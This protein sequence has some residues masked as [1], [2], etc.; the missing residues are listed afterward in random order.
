MVDQI[1]TTP[2]D[3]F[4]LWQ[5]AKYASILLH[6]P[7]RR[8]H[9]FYSFICCL[10]TE[11]ERQG[12][13]DRL[14]EKAKKLEGSDKKT[15]PLQK[16][17]FSDLREVLDS[18]VSKPHQLSYS[19]ESIIEKSRKILDIFL[20]E[21]ST[22]LTRKAETLNHLQKTSLLE[23]HLIEIQQFFQLNNVDI[24]ILRFFF[25][26]QTFEPARRYFLTSLDINDGYRNIEHIRKLLLISSNDI[27][28][29]LGEQG[30]LIVSGLISSNRKSLELSA[31][32]LD[33]LSGATEGPLTGHFFRQETS[34]LK[35]SFSDFPFQPKE[36][37][38]LQRILSSPIGSNIIF[39]GPPGAG[40][41]EFAKTLIHHSGKSGFFITDT[42][43]TAVGGDDLRR[44][45]LVAATN[46]LPSSES[47]I[48]VDEAE[49]IL[50]L[51]GRRSLGFGD[52]GLFSKKDESPDKAWINHF[53][54][55]SK[56]QIIWIVNEHHLLSEAVLRRFTFSMLFPRLGI[57]HREKAWSLQI[58]K[59]NANFISEATIKKL[60]RQFEVSPAAIALAIDT[61]MG[62]SRGKNNNLDTS[63]PSEVESTL[64]TLLQRHS[65]LLFGTSRK[66]LLTSANFSLEGLNTNIPLTDIIESSRQFLNYLETTSE[67]SLKI[68]N[69]NVLLFGPPGTGKTE[70]A[71][72]LA[73]SLDKNIQIKRG[74]D[75]LSKWVGDTEKNIHQAFEQAEAK[76]DILFLDESDSLFISREGANQSW[77]VS[78]T[79]E[80]LVQMEQFKGIL[81][82]STNFMD[83][84]DH[85]AIRRFNWKVRFE[86]LT[87][88]GK[89]SFYQAI[90]GSL[91]GQTMTTL[92]QNELA[93]IANLTPGDFKVVHQKNAFRQNVTHTELLASLAM[94]ASLKSKQFGRPI[95]F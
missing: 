20:T 29:A 73:R 16:D 53:L 56:H 40:K 62:M 94:E 67:A 45:A 23:S 5:T 52:L 90:L 27:R 6:N 79:S 33:Y 14:F 89:L 41:T 95:G 32:A 60:S 92:Q 8:D 12:V 66:P 57:K 50:A 2:D 81:I 74:S 63:N 82:C 39:Y 65:E 76:Q 10:L 84:M 11:N 42:K 49:H 70:F 69:M 55:S 78:Q 43:N 9:D 34:E 91:A 37:E 59:K 31:H 87:D 72:Y 36:I 77:E 85:A 61:V 93:K 83:N 7:I 25:I 30:Q 17:Y 54:E 19:F 28:K 51:G 46:I 18:V 71:K 26:I 64:E 13:A 35:L 22:E 21:I 88:T 68:R 47:I 24:G 80:L 75:L 58:E 1:S 38:I 44:S 48:V 4:I 3:E 15:S 86:F